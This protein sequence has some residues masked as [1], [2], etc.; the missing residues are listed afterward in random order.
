MF[1]PLF[2]LLF[3]AAAAPVEARVWLYSRHC[4]DNLNVAQVPQNYSDFGKFYLT[5]TLS[6]CCFC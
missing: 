5:R 3:L 6:V 2:I 1:A 4:A